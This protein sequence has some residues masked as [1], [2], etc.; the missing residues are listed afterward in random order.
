LQPEK[1][2]LLKTPMADYLTA[3]YDANV[4][5]PAPLRDLVMY[6]AMTDLFAARWSNDIH[7]EW[8]T[9]VLRNRPDL[10]RAKLERTRRFM[11]KSVRDALVAGY[12]ALIPTLKLP[13]PN[14]RHVLAAA[15]HAGADVIVTMNLKDF[16]KATL[17]KYGIVAQRPDD[18]VMR[19]VAMDAEVVLR[20]ITLQQQSLKRPAKTMDEFLET[21]EQ[22][23]LEK[24]TKWLRTKLYR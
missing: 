10:A 12:E 17:S 20:A 11:D 2:L 1:Y 16:P 14:D 22:Q 19:L 3:L 23:R 18:F 24:T 8:M 13:D 5:Y 15:I 21:L 4:L 6:L 7:E 9:G